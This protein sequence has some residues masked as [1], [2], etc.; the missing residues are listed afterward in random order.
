MRLYLGNAAL[1][2]G[3]ESK[4]KTATAPKSRMIPAARFTASATCTA[5]L[6]DGCSLNIDATIVVAINKYAKTK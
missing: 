6:R 5:S 3:T 4:P 2:L 1:R